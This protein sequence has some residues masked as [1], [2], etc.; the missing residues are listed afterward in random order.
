ML[1]KSLSPGMGQALRATAVLGGNC[2]RLSR[3][4]PT[5]RGSSDASMPV[6]SPDGTLLVRLLGGARRSRRLTVGQSETGRLLR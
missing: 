3:A 4:R 2:V 5:L 6:N 1:D